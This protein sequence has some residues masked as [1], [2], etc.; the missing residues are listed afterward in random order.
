MA[1]IYTPWS[2]LGAEYAPED[3][4]ATVTYQEGYDEAEDAAEGETTEAED[5]G[6]S[7]GDMMTEAM[8]IINE[9]QL[10]IKSL[11]AQLTG[12]QSE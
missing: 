1:E 9:Q 10:L 11:T 7:H 3:N 8:S 12:T 2:N 4:S 6:S 5:E